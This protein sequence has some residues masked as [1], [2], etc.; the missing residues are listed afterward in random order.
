[1]RPNLRYNKGLDRFTLRGQK[2]VETQWKLFCLVHNI[3]KQPHH[4]HAQQEERGRT[5]LKARLQTASLESRRWWYG[6]LISP[7][8]K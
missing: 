1:M 8:A 7:T 3:E 5:S 6:D 2:K 4:G